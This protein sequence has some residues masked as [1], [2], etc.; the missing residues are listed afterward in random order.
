MVKKK[1][2]R[3]YS[4]ECLKYEFIPTLT[5]VQLPLC[6][7]SNEAVKPSRLSDH[8]E[9]MHSDKV[10]KPI[11]FFQG[12][13]AKFENRSTVGKL[14]G[15]FALN[16]D[17]GLLASY[18]VSL[19]ISQCG[20]SHTIGETLVLP[21]VKEIVSTML[22]PDTCAMVKS[23]PLS[24]E[25]ISRRIDGMAA[26]VEENA[27]GRVNE[28]R[29]CNNEEVVEE[30]LFTGNVTTDTKGS[31][32]YKRVEEFFQEKNIPL[33]NVLACAA[34]R[35]ASMIGRYC[36]FIVH[37]KS[38][39]PGIMVVHCVIHRQHLVAKHLCERLHDVFSTSSITTMMKNS[40]V[41]S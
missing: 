35:A 7:V 21:A 30:R 33:T 6:L 15:K 2:C 34:D 12:L 5:N 9:K 10:G 8:L 28:H 18:K 17:K 26:D 11:S 19:L 16:A 41:Y 37:L 32:I 39:I 38:A 36:G 31:S 14:F 29:I 1:K 27:F 3:Q 13:K 40:N 20:K 4:N 25:T 24:K 22:G 23:I